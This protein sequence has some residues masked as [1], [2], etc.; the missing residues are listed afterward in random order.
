MNRGKFFTLIELLVVIAI[1]AILA[2]MLLPA[3][4]QARSRAKS[5]QCV[6]NLKQISTYLALYSGDNN[7]FILLGEEEAWMPILWRGYARPGDAALTDAEINNLAPFE[8]TPFRCP[9]NTYTHS[10]RFSYGINR[11]LNL[12][13][14]ADRASAVEQRKLTFFR[15]PGQTMQVTDN[16]SYN[17]TINRI[18]QRGGMAALLNDRGV[19]ESQSGLLPTLKRE[20]RQYRHGGGSFLNLG[21]LDGHVSS[22]QGGELDLSGY[23]PLMWAGKE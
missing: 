21:W 20:D 2:A 14:P 9:A 15:K 23:H 5:I 22:P 1:I 16:G 10:S 18:A 17:G 12:L 19:V 4:N 6:N 8:G 3:L 11:Q 13:N 7:D